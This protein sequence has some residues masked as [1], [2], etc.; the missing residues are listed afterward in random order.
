MHIVELQ[1][2][3]VRH[4]AHFIVEIQNELHAQKVHSACFAHHEV[5]HVTQH[6]SVDAQMLQH[7]WVDNG[8]VCIV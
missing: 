8:I 3:L 1:A 2:T 6:V 5:E 7:E 4:V